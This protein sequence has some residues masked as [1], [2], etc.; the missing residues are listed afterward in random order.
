MSH[1]EKFGGFEMTKE[2]C[3]DIDFARHRLASLVLW[4]IPIAL[5]AT[6]LFMVSQRGRLWPLAFAWAGVGCVLNAKSCGRVHCTFTGPLYLLVAL[7]GLLSSAGIWRM[8]WGWLWTGA[9]IGTIISFVP[10][11]RGSIYW[12]EK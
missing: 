6:G 1:F 12:E 8:G 2:C 11:W 9:I 5:A 7:L 10:E 4:Y 3:H